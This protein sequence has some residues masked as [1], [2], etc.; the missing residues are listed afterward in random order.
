METKSIFASVTFWGTIVA[1]FAP[2][3]MKYGFDVSG[4]ETTLAAVAGGVIAIFGRVKA[5]TKV[6]LV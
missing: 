1:V 4:M 3:A 5:R 2:L 6:S